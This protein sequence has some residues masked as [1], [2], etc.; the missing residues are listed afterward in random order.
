MGRLLGPRLDLRV[1]QSLAHEPLGWLPWRSQLA[2]HVL[3]YFDEGAGRLKDVLLGSRLNEMLRLLLLLLDVQPRV[4]LI[5]DSE[6][7][8]FHL[9]LLKRPLQMQGVLP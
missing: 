6:V 5:L 9:R 3:L 2:P 8:L 7:R 4:A 1:L